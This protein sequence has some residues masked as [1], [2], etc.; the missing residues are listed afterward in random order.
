[1][2]DFSS[3]EQ[4]VG[5]HAATF[6]VC[7]VSGL[8]PIVNAEIYLLS[9]GA[10]VPHEQV[11][12]LL[13]PAALGQV[14]AKSILYFAGTGALRLPRGKVMQ[15][16]EGVQ[17]RIESSRFPAGVIVLLS[18]IIGLPPLY[19]VSIAA[20]VLRIR[21]V[22]FVAAA[23]AGRLVRF[24]VLLEFPGLVKQVLA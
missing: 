15:K 9:V 3:L 10:L 22:V 21:F 7:L 18:A 20:G 1:M 4:S 2:L 12:S 8:V 5:L 19:L 11:L 13:A 23:L 17:K 24:A 14:I 16:L 6:V